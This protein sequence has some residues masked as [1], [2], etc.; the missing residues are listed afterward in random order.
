VRREIEWEEALARA[1]IEK[2]K[3]EQRFL[4]QED[5]EKGTLAGGEQHQT[6]QQ[7]ARPRFGDVLFSRAAEAAMSDPRQQHGDHLTSPAVFQDALENNR[8][9]LAC[10]TPEEAAKSHREAEFAKAVERYAP[11]Y[12]AGEIVIV[13]EQ[14]K[15]GTSGR[16]HKLDQQKAEDYM[17]CLALDKSQLQGI[18]GAKQTLD[19]RA[20]VRQRAIETAE[21]RKARGPQRGGLVQQ[22]MWTLQRLREAEQQR[23]REAEQQRQREQERRKYSDKQKRDSGE[24]D[25]ER[26]RLHPEYR[27]HVQNTRSWKSPEDKQRDRENAARA[28]IEERDRGR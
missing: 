26:Y 27:R 11:E 13:R 20:E 21:Q 8:L 22:Q 16:V 2:E 7:P 14:L 28:F 4:A 3:I 6:E 9:G 24:P 10:A 18:E 5:R 23:L 1:A 25:P 19:D 17:R 12:Q 15:N